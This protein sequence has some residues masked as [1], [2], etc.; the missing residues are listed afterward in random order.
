MHA[1]YQTVAGGVSE[2]LWGSARAEDTICMSFVKQ[3]SVKNGK[4]DQTPYL[5]DF[6]MSG[7]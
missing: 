2:E 5:I 7:R 1:T 6:V 3:T 4:I